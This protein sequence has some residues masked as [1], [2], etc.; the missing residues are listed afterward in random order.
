MATK[1]TFKKQKKETGL[2]G[3]GHPYPDTTIKLDK[4]QVGYISAPSWS[5]KDDLWRVHFT[6]KDEN[7]KCGFKWVTLKATFTEE[8][9]A[10]EFLNKNF[11]QLITLNLFQ[12]EPDEE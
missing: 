8:P 11:D 4:M 5:S 12:M 7:E 6:Q 3:V 2:A 9:L 10:R 1:F